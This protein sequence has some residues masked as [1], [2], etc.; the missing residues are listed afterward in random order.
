MITF[1][2]PVSNIAVMYQMIRDKIE[3]TAGGVP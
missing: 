3:K 2:P 1:Y